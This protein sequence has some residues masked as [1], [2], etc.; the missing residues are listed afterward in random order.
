VSAIQQA[1]IAFGAVAGATDPSFSSVSVLLHMEGSNGGGVFTDDSQ[2][3]QT[4]SSG[5]GVLTKTDQF[6]FGSSSGYW[7]TGVVTLQY[8][9]GSHIDFG[10]GDFTIEARVRFFSVGSQQHLFDARNAGNTLGGLLYVTSGDVLTYYSNSAGGALISGATV[11]SGVWYAIAL[12]RVSGSTKLFV[13]GT[14]SGS[15]YTDSV[16]WNQTTMNLGLSVTSTAPFFGWMDE[17]RITKGVGRYSSNY[18][19]AAAAFPN[20]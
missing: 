20:S 13:D 1:L 18:T 19:P 8:G 10:T 3:A 4:I 17:V 16:N 5:S 15:T 9:S 12:S 11:T 6:V 14:Q 2:Y 7:S